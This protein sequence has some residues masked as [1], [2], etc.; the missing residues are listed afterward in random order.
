MAV[1]L[2]QIYHP[3]R[4][5]P[6]RPWTISS[7]LFFLRREDLRGLDHGIKYLVLKDSLPLW[8]EAQQE[9]N[10]WKLKGEQ[11]KWELILMY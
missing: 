7:K 9:S 4:N 3:N 2:S 8:E 1:D 11:Y 6:A 10:V 5:K